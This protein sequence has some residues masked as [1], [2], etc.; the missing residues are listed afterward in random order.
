MW[1]GLANEMWAMKYD[2]GPFQAEAVKSHREKLQQQVGSLN[3]CV[4]NKSPSI[5]Y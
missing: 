3:A 1:L 5:V 4:K 2:A